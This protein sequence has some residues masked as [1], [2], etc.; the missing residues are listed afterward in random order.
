MTPADYAKAR[1]GLLTDTMVTQGMVSMLPYERADGS[2]DF[3]LYVHGV[4]STG[5]LFQT[6]V[7]LIYSSPVGLELENNGTASA[8]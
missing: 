1:F 8:V 2:S 3:I 7:G 6:P 5:K 4:T